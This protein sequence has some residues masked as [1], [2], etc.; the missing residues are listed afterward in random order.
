MGR[1]VGTDDGEAVRNDIKT[2]HKH[3]RCG[4][5]QQATLALS[6]LDGTH[7]FGFQRRS[8]PAVFVKGKFIGGCNDG[9]GGCDV[10]AGGEVCESRR[11]TGKWLECICPNG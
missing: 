8:V 11:E 9:P 7:V 3:S 10:H 5:P 4:I 1:A 6:L 2:V